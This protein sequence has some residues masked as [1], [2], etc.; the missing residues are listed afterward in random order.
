MTSTECSGFV[1]VLI[2]N[3]LKVGRSIRISVG[4]KC[5]KNFDTKKKNVD[6]FQWDSFMSLLSIETE[7]NRI[8]MGNVIPYEPKPVVTGLNRLG[9]GSS[10]RSVLHVAR[11]RNH[12]RGFNRVMGW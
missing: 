7:N 5:W 4:K 2:Q 1:K 3:S 12:N 9:F 11:T 6:F 8:M 10:F